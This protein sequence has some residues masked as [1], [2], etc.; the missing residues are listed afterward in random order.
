MIKYIQFLTKLFLI[1]VLSALISQVIAA[2]ISGSIFNVDFDMREELLHVLI[3]AAIL[4]PAAYFISFKPLILHSAELI[5]MKIAI[6]HEKVRLEEYFDVAA[7][8][9]VSIDSNEIV[10][11]INRRGLRTLGYEMSEVVGKDW[12]DNFVPQRTRQEERKYFRESILGK[13]PVLDYFESPVLTKSGVEKTIGWYLTIFKDPKD[14]VTG[15]LRSGHDITSLWRSKEVLLKRDYQLEILMRNSVHLKGSRD[16]ETVL[17]N[18][19][20]AAIELTDATA[21]AAGVIEN[22]RIVV[23]EYIHNGKA[24]PIQYIF[25]EGH[26]VAGWVLVS[27]RPYFMNEA[28]KYSNAMTL[29]KDVLDIY[30]IIDVPIIGKDGEVLG[31]L[32]VYNKINSDVFDVQDVIMLQGLAASAAVALESLQSKVNNVA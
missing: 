14:N 7:A 29:V 20:V 28:K 11:Y 19:V 6:G 17:R 25:E 1:I 16:P 32:E 10:D 2:I 5:Q 26:G 24:Q 31:C 30:N 23:R 15:V 12:F 22:G 8:I 13:K 9:I 21:G 4:C 3:L 27:K 18:L